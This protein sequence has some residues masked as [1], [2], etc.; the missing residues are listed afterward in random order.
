MEYEFTLKF[1]VP[2]S[3]W[4][5]DELVERLGKAGCN[6]ALV[7]LGLPGRLALDFTRESTSAER[8]IVSA[9]KDVKKAIPSA[10]LVEV[11][12]DVVGLSDVADLLGVSRQNIRKLAFKH[13]DF[14]LPFHSGTTV[15][16]RLF[17]VVEWYGA[18]RGFSIDQRL[19][20]V[21]GV[22]MQLN[23][24]AKPVKV[25]KRVERE[26]SDFRLAPSVRARLG[27]AVKK[28]SRARSW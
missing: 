16:W 6:D 18:P 15:L 17:D 7:G 5:A 21:S 4:D 13:E 23:S 26:L 1:V 25:T 28:S 10:S 22:A 8:A 20:E 19:K 12:P 24:L 3:E 27:T 2:R 14:P 11:G 9:I